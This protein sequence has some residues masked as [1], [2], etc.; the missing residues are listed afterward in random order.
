MAWP[1]PALAAL[2]LVAALQEK[3]PAAGEQ[4][5]LIEAYFAA[6]WTK[7]EGRAERSKILQELERVPLDASAAAANLKL[8]LERSS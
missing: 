2:A 5:K 8:V 7:P 4:K 1:H 6:D 3:P